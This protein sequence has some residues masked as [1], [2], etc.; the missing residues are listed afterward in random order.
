MTLRFETMALIA[1]LFIMGMFVAMWLIGTLMAKRQR[2]FD[3]N[4]K[5]INWSIRVIPITPGNYEFIE[6][7]FDE[8]G[9]L[10]ESRDSRNLEKLEV[11]YE[12]FEKKFGRLNKAI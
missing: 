12:E 7:L 9:K 8:I 10:P 6:N 5:Q 4:L 2:R 3:V 1:I 11:L